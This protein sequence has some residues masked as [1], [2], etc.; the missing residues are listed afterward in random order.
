MPT[1]ANIVIK[2]YDGTTN[3]T[4]TAVQGSSGDKTEATFVNNS[5]GTTP[6]EYPRLSV[7]SQSNGPKTARR[8][9]GSFLWPTMKQDAGG[10]KIATGGASGTFSLLV[11][12]NQPLT[13]I[14]EQAAQFG[15]L[16]A[17]ALIRAAMIEG[18]APR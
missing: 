7:W 16:V 13:D 3:V 12:Q 1:L 4:Y 11:P 18:Y 10:N 17:A 14:Q 2:K 9:S 5:V 6:M 8:L 15:N